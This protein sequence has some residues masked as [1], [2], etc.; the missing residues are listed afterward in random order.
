MSK[1][2]KTKTNEEYLDKQSKKVSS[3]DINKL[4]KKKRRLQ[5]ILSLKAFSSKKKKLKLFI[6]ILRQYQ[7]GEYRQIPWRSV[8]AIAFTLLY[9]INPL[10]FVPDVLPIIGYIDDVSVFMTLISLAEK[11]LNEFEEWKATQGLE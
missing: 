11:D 9:I 2:N 3:K 4:T 5:K 1:P 7:K 6:E 10:D 8:S